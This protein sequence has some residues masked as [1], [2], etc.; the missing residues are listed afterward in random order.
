MEAWGRTRALWV[1]SRPSGPGCG[2][3]PRHLPRPN[4]R[5]ARSG[6]VGGREVRGGTRP[7][8]CSGR[9]LRARG[10]RERWAQGP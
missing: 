3:S 4:P 9:H 5:S 2:L 10:H 6:A 1:V 7:P 8:T